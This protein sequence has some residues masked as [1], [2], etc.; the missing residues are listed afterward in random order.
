MVY[1]IVANAGLRISSAAQ[2]NTVSLEHP[3]TF[4]TMMYYAKMKGFN[5]DT[6][7]GLEIKNIVSKHDVNLFDRVLTS[8]TT[9]S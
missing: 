4:I 3:T 9:Q 2:I 8:I 7:L 1:N 6:K 5:S